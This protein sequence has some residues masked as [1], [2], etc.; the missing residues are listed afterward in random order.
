MQDSRPVNFAV[1]LY[2]NGNIRMLY[3]SGNEHTSSRV[4][5]RDKTIGIS[6]GEST[7]FHLG[8]RNGQHTLDG[9]YAIE[10]SCSGAV[11]PVPAIMDILLPSS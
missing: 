4:P 11:C 1:R 7:T 9:A 6:K 10:Y 8:L 5:K 3:G 2:A